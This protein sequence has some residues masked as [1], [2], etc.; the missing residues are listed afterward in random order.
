MVLGGH[1]LRSLLVV[2]AQVV[3]GGSGG[4]V[5]DAA[6]QVHGMASSQ[7]P[8]RGGRDSSQ[9]ITL[10]VPASRLAQRLADSANLPTPTPCT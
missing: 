4:P 10:A 2:D 7:I 9:V 3:T 6:G 8:G 1:T 5:V